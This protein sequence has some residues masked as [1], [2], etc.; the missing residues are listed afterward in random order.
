MNIK[1]KKKL[2]KEWFLKLQNL[3]CDNIEKLEKDYGSPI[4]FNLK[5]KNGNMANIEL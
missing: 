4:K 5:E 1:F 2:A 3:I